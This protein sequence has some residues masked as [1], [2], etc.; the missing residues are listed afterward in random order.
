M[1]LYTSIK[2]WFYWI[3]TVYLS[4]DH[5]FT[6]YAWVISIYGF[7]NKLLTFIGQC[8]MH[9]AWKIRKFQFSKPQ[10]LIF[11]F[12]FQFKN[13]QRL[14]FYKADFCNM[15]PLYLFLIKR[16]KV[17]IN[18]KYPTAKTT[19]FTECTKKLSTPVLY[20]KVRFFLLL[21]GYSLSNVI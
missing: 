7:S 2:F 17:K 13:A 10:I 8:S 19:C 14:A 21:N 16:T 12:E 18:A 5:Q 15:V 3:Y 11:F 20:A 6:I 4:T 9:T 1:L